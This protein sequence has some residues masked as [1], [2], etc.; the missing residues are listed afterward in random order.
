MTIDYYDLIFGFKISLTDYK[1]LMGFTVANITPDIRA[2]CMAETGHNDDRSVTYYMMM[3][4]DHNNE[5]YHAFTRDFEINGIGF[6]VRGFTHDKDEHKTHLIVGVDIGRIEIRSGVVERYER[7]FKK[8]LETLVNC[9]EWANVIRNS[10]NLNECYYIKQNDY[11]VPTK[12]M[13]EWFI[14][15]MTYLIQNDCKCC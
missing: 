14:T 1:N 3:A 10:E 4:V 5:R 6:T 8:H 13:C 12:G 9:E 11:S 15:P 2:E 7:D